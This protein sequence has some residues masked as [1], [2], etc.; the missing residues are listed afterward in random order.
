MTRTVR[1]QGGRSARGSWEPA[2]R[3]SS[4]RIL[5]RRSARA[6]PWGASWSPSP[7]TAATDAESH[8]ARPPRSTSSPTAPRTSAADRPD[9]NHTLWGQRARGPGQLPGPCSFCRHAFVA[10][11][12]AS[13]QPVHDKG[14]HRE[15]MRVVT[16]QH[17]HEHV[18]GTVVS[19]D[20]RDTEPAD[21]AIAAATAWLHA[22]DASFSPYRADS[23]LARLDRGELLPS[24][25]SPDV[26]AVLSRCAR[27][28]TETARVLRR[29]GRRTARPLRAREGLG[30]RVGSRD[31]GRGRPAELL[32]ERRRRPRDLR[33]RAARGR[34][35]GRRSST[36]ASGRRSRPW[37]APATSPWPPRGCTSVAPISVDPGTGRAPDGVLSVTVTGPDLGTRG[38]LLDCRLRD[39][40]GRA[41]L[42]AHASRATRP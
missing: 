26:Q 17:H 8:G 1:P 10:V 28:R 22:V 4:Q 27:L 12:S 42:D 39:G 29:A 14:R 37:C 2:G 11:L 40:H 34:V 30:R 32:R 36:P 24:E 20:V 13:S 5:S 25:A 15:Q 21:A 35:A 23:E 9:A 33:R 19:F 16:R 18:M 3:R 7:T 31:A 41:G 38:R 6:Q